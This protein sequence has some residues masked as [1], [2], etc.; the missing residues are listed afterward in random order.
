MKIFEKAFFWFK[1]ARLY[2]V[3]TSVVP[4]LFAVFLASQKVDVNV[5][6]S[7]LGFI[8]VVLAHLSI[9]LL[10]DYFDWKKGAVEEY[11]KLLEVGMQARTHK[12]YYLED[13]TATLNQLLAA[14]ATM[15]FIACVCGFIIYL[16]VGWSVVLIAAL[17]GFFAF[18]YS[19]SPFKWSYRGLGEPVIGIIFGPLIMFGAYITA[20]AQIDSRLILSSIILGIIIANIAYTHAI[21][22]YDSDVKVGKK[23]FPIR[24]GSKENAI[25]FLGVFY[26]LAYLLVMVGIILKIYPLVSMIVFITLPK[27][28]ALVK[29]MNTEDRTPKFWMGIMENWQ[30]LKAEGSD[31][32]ML[33]LCLSRNLVVDF[34][35]LLGISL[36]YN[37]S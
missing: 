21:M 11:K 28:L 25:T 24:F 17:A 27:A 33:R 4:Y 13:K 26:L 1:A 34:V 2:T 16:K 5:L 12:C 14:I 15:D 7:V 32:F 3:A 9:N 23:S 36:C 22:D 29:L 8:G 10:D 19:A 30:K 18:F 31:W 35:I 6:L 20:G 37:A